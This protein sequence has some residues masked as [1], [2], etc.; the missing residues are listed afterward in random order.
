[1]ICDIYRVIMARFLGFRALEPKQR[2]AAMNHALFLPFCSDQSP[3][4]LPQREIQGLP[5]TATVAACGS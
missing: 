5:P 2:A 4:G 3:I 1:M